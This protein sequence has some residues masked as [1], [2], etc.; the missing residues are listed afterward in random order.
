MIPDLLRWV[1][2]A[3]AVAAVEAMAA[4]ADIEA[5]VVVVAATLLLMPRHSVEADGKEG[6]ICYRL[7]N[8]FTSTN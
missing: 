3:V 8:C 1:A 2:T 6:R 4:E 5:D 7:A